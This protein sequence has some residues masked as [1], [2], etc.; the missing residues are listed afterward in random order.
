M[1]ISGPV[2]TVATVHALAESRYDE[3]FD[4]KQTDLIEVRVKRRHRYGRD[5]G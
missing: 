5:A 2:D 3:G 4:W 1:S